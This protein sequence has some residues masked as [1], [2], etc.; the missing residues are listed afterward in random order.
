MNS[1]VESASALGLGGWLA[2]STLATFIMLLGILF[3]QLAPQLRNH[4]RTYELGAAV[5][6]L[7]FIVLVTLASIAGTVS[8]MLPIVVGAV[9][10]VLGAIVFFAASRGHYFGTVSDYE[11][12]GRALLIVGGAVAAFGVVVLLL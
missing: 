7:A 9:W 12:I 2:F 8:P 10:L 6:G 3:S 1:P 5:A 4:R 11:I